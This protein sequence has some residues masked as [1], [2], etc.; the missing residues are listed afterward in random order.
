MNSLL[1]Q[2]IGN[3]TTIKQIRETAEAFGI[4]V[5]RH[6]ESSY[7]ALCELALDLAIDRN[8]KIWLLEV[9][10]KPS[11]EVFK[12]AG[13]REV[14][15]K[16]IVRPIEYALWAYRQKKESRGSKSSLSKGI[17]LEQRQQLD[18]LDDFAERL[19]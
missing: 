14:Y 11:R 4:S 10:P 9:N 16:A 17:N 2:W 13:E 6:L 7:G 19:D 18:E 12:Q 8:G 3:E 1:R 15:R 5:A